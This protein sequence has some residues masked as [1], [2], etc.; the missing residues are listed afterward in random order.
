[1]VQYQPPDQEKHPMTLAAHLSLVSFA[2]G[3]ILI[4]SLLHPFKYG[5]FCRWKY[6]YNVFITSNATYVYRPTVN[7][8]LDHLEK[9]TYLSLSIFS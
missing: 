4:M 3:S 1:M 8:L 7:F 6:T 9:R 5:K 2:G